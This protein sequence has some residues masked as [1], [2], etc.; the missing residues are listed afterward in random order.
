MR[1]PDRTALVVALISACIALV[2]WLFPFHPVGISPIVNL[3]K[4]G[5]APKSDGIGSAD[6]GK[7]IQVESP[8]IDRVQSRAAATDFVRIRP[9]SSPQQAANPPR[10]G[11]STPVSP[12]GLLKTKPTNPI[13]D[14]SDQPLVMTA[15][16]FM[17]KEFDSGDYLA[18]GRSKLG[19]IFEISGPIVENKQIDGGV[20]TMGVGRIN[21]GLTLCFYDL[22][23]EGEPISTYFRRSERSAFDL[24][25]RVTIRGN[26][27]RAAWSDD[28]KKVEFVACELIAWPGMEKKE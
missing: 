27:K 14:D 22:K 17:K 10:A 5:A 8:A 26:Y 1:R 7:A 6:Q 19:F 11:N 13:L 18:I 16:E 25:N 24:G 4:G 12:A 15:T 2:S 21:S 28:Y 20:I 9:T 3:Q 23:R